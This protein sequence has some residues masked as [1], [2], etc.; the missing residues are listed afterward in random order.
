MANFTK[1]IL[2][3]VLPSICSGFGKKIHTAGSLSSVSVLYCSLPQTA[4][5]ASALLTACS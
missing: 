3:P 1:K 4:P 2:P 5:L